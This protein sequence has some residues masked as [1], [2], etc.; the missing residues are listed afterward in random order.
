VWAVDLVGHLDCDAAASSIGMETDPDPVP[1]D[2]WPTPDEALEDFLADRPSL[3]ST[4]FSAPL[5]DGRWALHRYLVEGRPKVHAVSTNQFP[6][7]PSE[8]RWQVVGL[9][10]C[11]PEEFTTSTGSPS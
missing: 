2:A 1:F 8:A 7:A 3:P 6:G 9:R 10:A 5:I 11:Q 4:G